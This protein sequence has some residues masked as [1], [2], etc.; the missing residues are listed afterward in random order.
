MEQHETQFSCMLGETFFAIRL[1][2]KEVHAYNPYKMT[3]EIHEF[4]EKSWAKS[5]F[6]GEVR[7]ALQC[8]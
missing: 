5:Y 2:G 1:K 6:I 4:V 8:K 3:W 7:R